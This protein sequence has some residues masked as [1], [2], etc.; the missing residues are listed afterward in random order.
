MQVPIR[1]M[2]YRQFLDCVGCLFCSCCVG[3]LSF[4]SLGAHQEAQT[5]FI[6]MWSNLSVFSFVSCA[7]GKN[8]YQTA[9]HVALP[10]CFL[11]RV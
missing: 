8:H 11:Q 10:L 9:S 4:Y 6:L 5:F 1:D 7:F 2:I 3:G